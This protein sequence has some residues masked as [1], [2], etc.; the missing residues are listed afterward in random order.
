MVLTPPKET[1]YLRSRSKHTD[2]SGLCSYAVNMP[3]NTLYTIPHGTMNQVKKGK[4]VTPEYGFKTAGCM[5]F[6]ANRTADKP[7]G[8]HVALS[9]GE[10]T[11]IEAFGVTKGIVE[12]DIAGW[13]KRK[14]VF[15]IDPFHRSEEKTFFQKVQEKVVSTHEVVTQLAKKIVTPPTKAIPPSTGKDATP[16]E[17]ETFPFWVVPLGVFG[18]VMLVFAGSVFIIGRK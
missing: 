3:E 8:G 2:C 16:Q 13:M 7:G 12:Q 5:G 9:S 15:W 17:V 1:K 4:I 18:G 6:Y 11:V 10:G 14:L